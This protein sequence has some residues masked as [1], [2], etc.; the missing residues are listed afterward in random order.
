MNQSTKNL[1][2]DLFFILFA[3]I[4]FGVISLAFVSTLFFNFVIGL[5][6]AIILAYL[7]KNKRRGNN[8]KV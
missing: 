2:N 8:A 5:V 3:T 1:L 6:P 4:V 7:T